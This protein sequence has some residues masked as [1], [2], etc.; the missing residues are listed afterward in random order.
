MQIETCE[1]CGQQFVAGYGYSLAAC[2]MVSGSAFV[3]AYMCPQRQG[4]QHWGCTPEH[5]VQALQACLADP[6]HMHLDGLMQRHQDAHS[7]LQED[8]TTIQIPRYSEEDSAW[9]AGR[10]ENFHHVNIVFSSQ[11]G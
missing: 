9:A 6:T 5:A 7:R 2:W 4:G 1:V 3:A 11:G 10:G 8:G